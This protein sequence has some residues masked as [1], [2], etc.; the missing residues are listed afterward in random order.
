MTPADFFCSGRTIFATFP[1][2]ITDE[3]TRKREASLTKERRTA[4]LR[5]LHSVN[6]AL[7]LRF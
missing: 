1:I 6:V 4:L 5:Q 3:W 7:L 2:I